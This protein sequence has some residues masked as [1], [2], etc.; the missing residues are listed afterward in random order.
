M[1]RFEKVSKRYAA[2]PPALD[3]VSFRVERGE[4]AFLTG[5]SGAG[6]A[7]QTWSL[8]DSP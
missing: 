7:L 8:E 2:G 3:D 5:P 4:F 6:I 1:I